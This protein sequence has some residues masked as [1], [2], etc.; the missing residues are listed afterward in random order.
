M[1]RIIARGGERECREDERQRVL[2][3]TGSGREV[4]HHFDVRPACALVV[5]ELLQGLGRIQR[6]ERVEIRA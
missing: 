4:V 3:V 5:G 2:V 1:L 6:I